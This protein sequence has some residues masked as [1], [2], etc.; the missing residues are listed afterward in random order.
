MVPSGNMTTISP[1]RASRIAVRIASRSP[2]PRRT[3]NAPPPFRIGVNSGLKSSAFA[4]KRSCLCG[5][6][7]IPSAHGSK[8][9]T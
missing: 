9:E 8:F 3:L 2:S 7:G 4:M 5:H 6:N 1:S